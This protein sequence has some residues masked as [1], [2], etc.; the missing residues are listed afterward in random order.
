MAHSFARPFGHIV[1]EEIQR[2]GVAVALGHAQHPDRRAHVRDPSA[3]TA[4]GVQASDVV[5][6]ADDRR[7]GDDL[8]IDRGV[9]VACLLA[10]D[11][12]VP[13][14]GDAAVF[15]AANDFAG[16]DGE[17]VVPGLAGGGSFVVLA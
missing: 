12:G 6:Q 5:V 15:V 7:A 1:V 14:E 8:E 13:M 11:G 9:E 2:I 16:L 3:V 17:L 10:V 4:F